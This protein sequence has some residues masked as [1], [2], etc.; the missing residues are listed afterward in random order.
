[1]SYTGGGEGVG[2]GSGPEYVVHG[3]VPLCL[4]GHHVVVN[5]EHG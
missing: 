3:M 1:M 5:G 2:V 4:D